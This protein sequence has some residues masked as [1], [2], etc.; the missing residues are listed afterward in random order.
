MFKF[1]YEQDCV[2]FDKG[3]KVV[4]RGARV[5]KVMYDG[6][7]YYVHSGAVEESPE[8]GKPDRNPSGGG[9]I[10]AF[11]KGALISV[12]LLVFLFLSW[13]LIVLLKSRKQVID[14]E[15]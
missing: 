9:I 2:V 3:T 7:R 5:S 14:E 1:M 12:L 11:F 10:A 15:K 4:V 13:F 8:G 6:S